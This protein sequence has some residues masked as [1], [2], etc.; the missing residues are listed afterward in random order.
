LIT[1]L[2]QKIMKDPDFTYEKARVVGGPIEALYLWT[3]AMYNFN[4]IYT[5]TQPLR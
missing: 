4:I 3:M 5:N 2:S 1:K